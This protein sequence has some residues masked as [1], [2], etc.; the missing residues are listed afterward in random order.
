MVMTTSEGVLIQKDYFNQISHWELQLEGD[1]LNVDLM[2]VT[3]D[4][5]DEIVVCKSDGV[6]YI[7]DQSQNIAKFKFDDRVSAFTSGTKMTVV[8]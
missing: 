1:V 3:S 8:C 5:N 2:D 7:I 4:G 6:T